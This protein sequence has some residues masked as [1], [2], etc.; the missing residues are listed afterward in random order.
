MVPISSPCLSHCMS[1]SFKM[2][3]LLSAI[4]ARDFRDLLTLP[5]Q[6]SSS[7]S[8]QSL[9]NSHLKCC[10]QAFCRYAMSEQMAECAI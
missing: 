7:N 8:L 4:K 3:V 1:F 10:T 5:C 6:V 2:V 9:F